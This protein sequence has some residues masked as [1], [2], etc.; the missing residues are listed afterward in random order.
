MRMEKEN[1]LIEYIGSWVLAIG[2]NINA[3]ASTP[4]PL[5]TDEQLEEINLVGFELQAL[6]FAIQADGQSELNLESGG[7]AI[8]AIGM[9]EIISSILLPFSE[10][11]DTKL[12]ISGNLLASLGAFM[13][14]IEERFHE[15]LQPGQG[16]ETIG[17]LMQAI[18]AGVLAIALKL[19]ATQ[20][21]EEAKDQKKTEEEEEE[22]EEKSISITNL[23]TWSNWLVAA[24]TI[25]ALIGVGIQFSREN[26]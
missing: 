23:I 14:F 8:A 2:A 19:Q 7:N 20:K 16:L 4:N 22:D 21:D 24:G 26:Q 11:T 13:I 17:N 18:G 10:K 15:P 9:L 5:L 3:A 6:G 1:L 12:E 25:V